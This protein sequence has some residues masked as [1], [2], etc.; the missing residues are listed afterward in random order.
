MML[1]EN[2]TLRMK[3]LILNPERNVRIH[4]EIEIADDS[5][6]VQA[7]AMQE[8]LDYGRNQRKERVVS[9]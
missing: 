4:L 1:T 6:D 2:K 8:M 3:Y 7:A 5:P 9:R